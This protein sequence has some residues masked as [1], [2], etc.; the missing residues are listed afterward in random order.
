[1][2]YVPL[3]YTSTV[4]LGPTGKPPTG[5]LLSDVMKAQETRAAWCPPTVIE[6][7]LEIPG[8]FEQAAKLDFIMYTGGPLAPAAGDKL[9]QV[10]DICQLYGSTESGTQ[11]TLIP[12]R[13]TWQYFEWHPHLSNEMESLGDGTYEMV[14]H[15]NLEQL[16]FRQIYHTFPELDTYRTNDLFVQHPE[17][18][19]LWKFHG[20]RDDVIVLGN[21][22]KFNPVTMEGIVSGDPLVHG[23]LIVGMKRTQAALLVEPRPGH[24]LSRKD[25]ITQIWPTIQKANA[26]GPGHGRIYPSKI[27][28]ATDDRPFIRAG[29]GTVIRRHNI[30]Q[31]EKEIEAVYSSNEED[32]P[33]IGPVLEIPSTSGEIKSVI[34]GYIASYLPDIAEKITD[35]TDFFTVNLDSLQTTEFSGYLKSWVKSSPEAEKLLPSPITTRTIY[36]NCSVNKLVS[37]FERCLNAANGTSLNGDSQSTKTDRISRIHAALGNFTIGLPQKYS[38]A[39][40]GSTGSLGTALLKTLI[41]DPRVGHVYCLDRADNAAERHRATFDAHG[42][43]E[44]LLK[45][46]TRVHFLKVN[47]G[48]G[49][50]FGLADEDY[51]HLLNHVDVVIHNAWAVNFNQTLSSFESVHLRGTRSLID[52]C[53]SSPR[54]P[55]LSFVSSVSAV[56]NWSNQYGNIP[57]PESIVSNPLVSLEMGYGESKYVAERLVEVGARSGLKASILRVGQIAG[58]LARSSHGEWNK[59]EWFPI[60][61]KTSLSLGCIPNELGLIDWIPVDTLAH[62]ISDLI[63]KPSAAE[64]L[65]VYNLVNPQKSEWKSLLPVVLDRWGLKAVAFA[66]WIEALSNAG[67]NFGEGTKLSLD[68]LPALKVKEFFVNMAADLKGSSNRAMSFVTTNGKEGSPAMARL[69]PIDAEAMETWLDQWNFEAR[70]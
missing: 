60:L 32:V 11:I 30:Q 47:F 51:F 55:H 39:L 9:C 50:R 64:Q 59:T 54:K 28:I 13:E 19:H 65:T 33:F 2:T 27:I 44:L 35:D 63:Q 12:T 38:I 49:S 14:I 10:T 3:F 15:K 5:K 62:I 45:N 7:L 20:R 22:E 24:G 25:F 23:A 16:W 46:A 4:L 56:Q 53:H 48:E 21:G 8:G 34:R 41:A 66:D 6:Q 18:P 36:E 57:V 58:P 37:Y 68:S 40:T 17:K 69:G 52:F 43:S 70:A 29:K 42:T 61:L 31:Y 26:A 67:A 1:M